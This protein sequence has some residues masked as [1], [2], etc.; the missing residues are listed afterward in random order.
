MALASGVGQVTGLFSGSV[1]GD[2]IQISGI[3]DWLNCQAP[4]GSMLTV[5]ADARRAGTPVVV[6]YDDTSR[7]LYTIQST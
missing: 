1:D 4:S 3:K 6:Y 2:W 7:A 5:A